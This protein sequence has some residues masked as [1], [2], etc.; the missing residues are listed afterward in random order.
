M[1]AT[2]YTPEQQSALYEIQDL[3]SANPLATRITLPLEKFQ[4]LECAIP[5][6]LRFVNSHMMDVCHF[7][8]GM[9]GTPFVVEDAPP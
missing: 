2:N 3:I 1:E 4:R 5:D 7:T 6:E 8:V 9:G